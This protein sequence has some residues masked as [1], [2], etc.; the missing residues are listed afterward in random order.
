MSKDVF[1][2]LDWATR[3]HAVCVI[4]AAG[5]VLDR[6]DILTTARPCTRCPTAC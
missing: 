1:V 3:A 6:F 5:T 2:G 4:D